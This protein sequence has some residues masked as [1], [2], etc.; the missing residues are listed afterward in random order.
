MIEALE[1]RKWKASTSD[2]VK[3]DLSIVNHEDCLLK[4]VM[5]ISSQLRSLRTC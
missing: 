2:R 5:T 4:L 1:L 3:M